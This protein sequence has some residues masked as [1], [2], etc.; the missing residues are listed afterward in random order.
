VEQIHIGAGL[1]DAD[2]DAIVRESELDAANLSDYLD[3]GF[4]RAFGGLD[5]RPR[6]RE[7][8]VEACGGGRRFSLPR[9]TRFNGDEQSET[10]LYLQS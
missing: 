2:D 1:P 7:R 3:G 5:P 6:M 9:G 8:Q 4:G 10:L